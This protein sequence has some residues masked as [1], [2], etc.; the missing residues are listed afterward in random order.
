MSTLLSFDDEGKWA[1]EEDDEEAETEFVK[2]KNSF[3]KAELL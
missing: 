1:E 3:A 2:K